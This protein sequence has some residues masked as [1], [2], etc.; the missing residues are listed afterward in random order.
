M[1]KTK[2]DNTIRAHRSEA[3]YGHI[4]RHIEPDKSVLAIGAGDCLIAK[5]IQE[6]KRS[7]VT[8]VDVMDSNLTDLDLVFYDGRRLPFKDLQFDT[9]LL[10]YV[11]HHC[12]E[13]SEVLGEARR[14]CRGRIVI[15]EDLYTGW[16]QKKLIHGL[17]WYLGKVA[18]MSG[19]LSFHSPEEWML[20]FNRLGLK[21]EDVINL[22][23]DDRLFP[24]KHIMFIASS[25]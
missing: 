13:P 25:F 24:V 10:C 6:R 7:G 12:L 14:V 20:I 18:R 8:V 2:I 21:V 3:A 19:P 22:G 16:F 5:K 15:L 17:H 1:L 9:V 23:R 11:L 4:E